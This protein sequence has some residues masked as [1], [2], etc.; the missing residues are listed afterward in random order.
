MLGLCAHLGDRG[1]GLIPAPLSAMLACGGRLSPGLGR[2][3]PAAGFPFEFRSLAR[4]SLIDLLGQGLTAS[5]E[6]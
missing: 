2:I 4:Y 6:D 1:Y 5:L 3:P